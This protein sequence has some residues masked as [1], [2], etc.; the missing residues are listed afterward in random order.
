MHNSLDHKAKI[1][2]EINSLTKEFDC[3]LVTCWECGN[4]LNEH[5]HS[6]N[7]EQEDGFNIY[8]IKCPICNLI[9]EQS[10]FPDLFY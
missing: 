4:I 9:D 10:S 8:L 3:H 6:F 7:Q 5:K 1:A 2:I